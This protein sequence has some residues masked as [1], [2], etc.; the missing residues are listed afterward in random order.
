MS[1]LALFNKQRKKELLSNSFTDCKQ[2]FAFSYSIPYYYCQ[3][4]FFSLHRI[5]RRNHTVKKKPRQFTS[6]IVM[7]EQWRFL[8][9]FIDYIDFI[10]SFICILVLLMFIT[11]LYFVWQCIIFFVHHSTTLRWNGT[12]DINVDKSTIWYNQN[13]L[14]V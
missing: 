14:P 9:D 7:T 11:L 8:R 12:I 13:F 4:R 5:V 6:D 10:L 2:L 1:C 3:L